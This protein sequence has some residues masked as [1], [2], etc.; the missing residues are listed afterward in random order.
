MRGDIVE[1]NSLIYALVEGVSGGTP[2]ADSS[3][4]S[5][6]GVVL[7]S[8]NGGL[9]LGWIILIAIVAALL[10]TTIF[11]LVYY[12]FFRLGRNSVGR[13]DISGN[14]RG[15]QADTYYPLS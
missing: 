7:S 3:W 4:L 1:Y 5:L 8:E 2:G 6:Q 10:I 12:F 13:M 14:A 11:F 15:V 9:D